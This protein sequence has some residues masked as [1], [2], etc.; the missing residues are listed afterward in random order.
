M[1]ISKKNILFSAAAVI[2]FFL[3]LELS[4]RLILFIIE[5]KVKVEFNKDGNPLFKATSDD[6]LGYKMNPESSIPGILEINSFGYMG[7]EVTLNKPTNTYRIITLGGSS[8]AGYQVW[9]E[10]SY[11]SI[12]EHLLKNNPPSEN[13]NYEVINGG[14][15][16]Y[17]SIQAYRSLVRD[18]IKFDPDLVIWMSGWNDLQQSYN[19]KWHPSILLQKKSK[20]SKLATYKII[21]IFLERFHLFPKAKTQHGTFNQ[22][23]YSYY[24]QNI[25]NTITFLK[26]KN[27]DIWLLSLPTAFGPDDPPDIDAFRI[28]F[29]DATPAD[30]KVKFSL[31]SYKRY[32]NAMKE[33]SVKYNI[34]FINSGLSDNKSGKKYFFTDILHPNNS[35]NKVIAYNLYKHFKDKNNSYNNSGKS[36]FNDFLVAETLYGNIEDPKKRDEYLVKLSQ[37]I[38]GTFS[39]NRKSVST[40]ISE[41]VINII[42]ACGLEEPFIEKHILALLTMIMEMSPEYPLTYFLYG[43][44]Q[45]DM[46][47][48]TQVENLFSTLAL[49]DKKFD[50]K[51]ALN[52]QIQSKSFGRIDKKKFKALFENTHPNL[53]M[54]HFYNIFS[55]IFG[56]FK[57]DGLGIYYAKK[58]LNS[59][60]QSVWAKWYLTLNLFQSGQIEKALP[61]AEEL[62]KE[63]DHPKKLNKLLKEIYLKKG[64][65]EKARKISEGSL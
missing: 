18:L 46:H 19:K 61:L 12:F 40:A 52:T 4:F 35:G 48:T 10:F 57:E 9:P 62:Y 51:K 7:K 15:G 23:A 58:A 63:P 30:E 28:A 2:L 14:V 39:N 16:G 36:V 56:M 44:I 29:G 65:E 26:E 43:K 31:F 8:T 42:K 54:E 32:Q 24:K 17:T 59:N 33:L 45:K 25:E 3:I 27:I 34:P 22:E 20:L 37:E 49:H 41:F 53:P 1:K 38:K 13:L 5:D 50:L 64:F 55:R 11:S 47:I 60:P 6:Y 21:K